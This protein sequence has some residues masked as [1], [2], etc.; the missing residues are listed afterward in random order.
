MCVSSFLKI[1]GHHLIN[2]N[3]EAL[4]VLAWEKLT[5]GGNRTIAELTIAAVRQ[6]SGNQLSNHIHRR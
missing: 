6:K 5:A 3:P 1:I 4:N 2:E